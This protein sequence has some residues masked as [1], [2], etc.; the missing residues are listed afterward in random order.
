LTAHATGFDRRDVLQALCQA[1]PPGLL[2][3]RARLEAAANVVLRHRDTIPLAIRTQDDGRWT[4]AE[5]LA[6]EQHA[7]T[8]AAQ[9]RSSRPPQRHT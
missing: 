9:L 6:V 2:V 3:D 8:V 5:L 1:L 4:S 7:L